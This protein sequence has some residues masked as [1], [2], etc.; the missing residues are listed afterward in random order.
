V[1]FVGLALRAERVP[2]MTA[3]DLR[4]AR[5]D[6]TSVT[7]VASGENLLR[8]EH[9]ISAG[10]LARRARKTKAFVQ[11]N[12]RRLMNYGASDAYVV[13]KATGYERSR[14]HAREVGSSHARP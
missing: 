10:T 1:R 5:H 4:R 14:S 7:C 3:I 6:A 9:M 11:R 12:I 2:K 13:E 8:W